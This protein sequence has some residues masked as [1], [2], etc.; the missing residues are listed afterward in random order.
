MA[1]ES[2]GSHRQLAFRGTN[3]C[4][5]F[6]IA[7]LPATANTK[8]LESKGLGRWWL[9]LPFSRQNKPSQSK[10]GHTMTTCDLTFFENLRSQLAQPQQ[11]Q[12]VQSNG[13]HARLSR[14]GEE[15]AERGCAGGDVAALLWYTQGWLAN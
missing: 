5:D 10:A 14:H 7:I 9:L 3:A 15:D 2:E 13:N 1:W 8:N 12:R 4:G 6:S 11:S